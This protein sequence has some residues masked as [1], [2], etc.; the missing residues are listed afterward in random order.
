[1]ASGKNCAPASGMK[2]GVNSS[3]DLIILPV[4]LTNFSTINITMNIK[5]VKMGHT[6]E[7][8]MARLL[9]QLTP[10]KKVRSKILKTR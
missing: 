8:T 2:A 10:K 5:T 3:Q 6:L 1:M 9:A 7:I 4:V